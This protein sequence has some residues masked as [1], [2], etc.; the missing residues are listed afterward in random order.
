[1]AI[2][3]GLKDVVETLVT[4]HGIDVSARRWAS[5]T[6]KDL[7]EN[8][9][10]II[11]AMVRGDASIVDTLLSSRKFVMRA[12]LGRNSLIYI[13]TAYAHLIETECIERL[14]SHQSFDANFILQDTRGTKCLSC[15]RCLDFFQHYANGQN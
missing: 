5:F 7:V 1:M 3:I 8:E 13:T 4:D 9:D 15:G 2:E 11:L 6:S 14:V 12:V 10:L